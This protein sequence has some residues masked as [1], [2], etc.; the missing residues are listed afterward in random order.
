MLTLLYSFSALISLLS[1]LALFS[2]FAL[3]YFF[4]NRRGARSPFSGKAMRHGKEFS[5]EAVSKVLAFLEAENDKDNLPFDLEKAAICEETGRI[6]PDALNAFEVVKLKKPYTKHFYKAKMEAL[7]NLSEKEQMDLREN[8]DN[9]SFFSKNSSI[10]V[11]R[12][13]GN[14]LAWKKIPETALELMLV[15]KIT[16]LRKR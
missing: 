10:F 5:F 15:K 1:L 11:D 16:D 14:I 3:G 12:E 2:F 13:K 7:E 4:C 8:C 6:F 9:F